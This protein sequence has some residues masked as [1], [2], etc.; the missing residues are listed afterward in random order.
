MHTHTHRSGSRGLRQPH[1]RGPPRLARRAP[2]LPQALQVLDVAVE[3]LPVREGPLQAREGPEDH[4]AGG[5]HGAGWAGAAGQR[6]SGDAL[7]RRRGRRR[8][9]V[10]FFFLEFLEGERETGGWRKNDE[11]THSLV[12]LSSNQS[13]DEQAATETST[14]ARAGTT[15]SSSR[16]CSRSSR[17]WRRELSRLRRGKHAQHRPRMKERGNLLPPIPTL[18]TSAPI[19]PGASASAA[20]SAPKAFWRARRR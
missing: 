5:G 17:A 2:A 11:K 16:R 20:G 18:S 9:C 12:S 3:G 1:R 15:A 4:R 19:S 8:R 10:F 7:A 14:P 13:I 6:D